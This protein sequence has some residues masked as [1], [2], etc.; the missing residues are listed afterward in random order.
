[1]IQEDWHDKYEISNKEQLSNIKVLPKLVDALNDKSENVKLSAIHEIRKFGSNA[2]EAGPVL[3]KLIENDE[4]EEVKIR[5]TLAIGEIQYDDERTINLLS[6]NLLLHRNP[7]VRNASAIAL[8]E[9][10][11]P[12]P[13]AM[14]ALRDASRMDKY[15]IVKTSA[16]K[17]YS[18]LSLNLAQSN[19]S[20][21]P[22]QKKDIK[23]IQKQLFIGLT[24]LDAI[25]V[26]PNICL[27][28]T[29][30]SPRD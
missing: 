21:I 15:E 26:A 2:K 19:H 27:L 28:Y 29:S 10:G 12:S 5:A 11:E 25:N 16:G 30:P 1:M 18:I 6:R 24:D 20:I 3:T 7:Y 4:S 9:I 22:E 14:S 17:S 13:G 8:G 23:K